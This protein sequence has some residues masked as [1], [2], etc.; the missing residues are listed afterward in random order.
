MERW[1]PKTTKGGE[2]AK[3]GRLGANNGW[4]GKTLTKSIWNVALSAPTTTDD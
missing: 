4:I 3:G 1:I 2:A